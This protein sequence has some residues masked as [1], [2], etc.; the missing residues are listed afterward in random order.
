MPVQLRPHQAANVTGLLKALAKF[1]GAL[2]GSDTGTGKT[3][4]ALALCQA[5]GGRPAIV[6]RK[7]IIPSWREACSEIGLDPVFVTNYE[8]LRSTAFPFGRI[9]TSPRGAKKYEWS[10]PEPRVVVIFDEAQALRGRDTL[11]SKAALAAHA[12]HKTLLLSATPFQ[13]PLEASTIGRIIGLFGANEYWRWLFSNGCKKNFAGHMEFVG[14]ARERRD[15]APGTNAQKGLQVMAKIH[16]SIFPERGVRTRREDIPGF[17]ESLLLCEA[18]ETGHADEITRHHLAAI[19]V[20]RAED[21]AKACEGVDP[22]FHDLVQPLALTQ[23]LRHRQQAEVLKAQSIAELAEMHHERDGASVAIFVNFDATV[24][25]LSEYLKCRHI[26]RGDNSGR[27]GNNLDRTNAV[28]AFQNNTAPYV[29]VNIRAGGAGLSLHDPATK[30]PRVALI[31]PPYSA[32]DL[33]QVLG[34]THRLGGGHST[35]KLLYAAGT[36]EES[37]MRRV[38]SRLDNLDTLLDS[39]VVI[40]C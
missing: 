27:A 37:V 21:H 40:R 39:D 22:E 2:D 6:T 13:T 25:L 24:E 33:K 3:Y 20:A 4:T 28:R 29:I 23:I 8:A 36:V 35:Q 18:L 10:I 7:A 26:I 34:R 16:G 1:G 30:R 11:N 14:D 15:Q 32:V 31:S 12:K 5:V 9:V 17:P 38:Q 19:E